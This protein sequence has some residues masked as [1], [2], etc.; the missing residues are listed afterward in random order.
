ML[1]Q[2]S[3]SD[4]CERLSP[5]LESSVWLQYLGWWG[6]GAEKLGANCEELCGV[7]PCITSLRG[8]GRGRGRDP[9]LTRHPKPVWHQGMGLLCPRLGEL[10]LSGSVDFLVT[11][12]Q[13]TVRAGTLGCSS[14]PPHQ[15]TSHTLLPFDTIPT[16]ADPDLDPQRYPA[17]LGLATSFGSHWRRRWH[18]PRDLGCPEPEHRRAGAPSLHPSLPS[19]L[20]SPLPG[21]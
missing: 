9:R 13:F 12:P 5:A 10:P 1:L 19:V 17:C 7:G 18:R 20:L 2:S 15:T 11:R 6:G 21:L 16:H 4:P 14:P 8:T 3:S